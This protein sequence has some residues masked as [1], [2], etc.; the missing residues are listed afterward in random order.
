MLLFSLSLS[1]LLCTSLSLLTKMRPATMADFP[2]EEVFVE[3]I[4]VEDMR[5]IV[6][7][8]NLSGV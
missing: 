1:L 2:L 8:V 4:E 6:R 5:K 3:D 7:L